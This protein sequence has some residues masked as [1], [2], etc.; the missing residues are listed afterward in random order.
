[1]YRPTG[2]EENPPLSAAA[3]NGYPKEDQL[4][5]NKLVD[6]LLGGS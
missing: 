5:G 4:A 3:E 1:M 2:F 6:R